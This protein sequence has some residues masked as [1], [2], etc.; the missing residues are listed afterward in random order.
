MVTRD[1]EFPR[2]A[3]DTPEPAFVPVRCPGCSAQVNVP[4]SHKFARCSLCGT[5]WA[6]RN[7]AMR[8]TLSG[9][10]R[11][12]ERHNPNALEIE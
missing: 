3:P 8:V 9:E 5:R 10:R 7:Q 6:W 4:A 2:P 12:E 1:E 11:Q